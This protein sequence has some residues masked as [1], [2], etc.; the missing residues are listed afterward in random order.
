MRV[1]AERSSI[2]K[3]IMKDTESDQDDRAR[4]ELYQI[5]FDFIETFFRWENNFQR[6]LKSLIIK[7]ETKRKREEL[8]MRLL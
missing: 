6:S 5:I 1:R 3:P 8:Q 4:I 2:L 7:G